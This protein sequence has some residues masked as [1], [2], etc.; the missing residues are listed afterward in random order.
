LRD[1]DLDELKAVFQAWIGRVEE[2]NE[3]NGDD[4][5]W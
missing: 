3:G 2:V 4:V 5:G 1:I